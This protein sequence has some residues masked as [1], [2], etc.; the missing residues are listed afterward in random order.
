MRKMQVKQ[1]K[2]T[3]HNLLQFT[4][5]LITFSTF[6]AFE[7]LRK[8]RVWGSLLIRS[9]CNTD[10]KYG[11]LCRHLFQRWK[12]FL[13]WSEHQNVQPTY[14]QES[15]VTD[16]GFDLASFASESSCK[17]AEIFYLSLVV[18]DTPSPIPHSTIRQ[19]QRGFSWVNRMDYRGKRVD[20]F[21]CVN[22]KPVISPFIWNHYRMSV[23]VPSLRSAVHSCLISLTSAQP[24]V[25]LSVPEVPFHL[26]KPPTSSCFHCSST[27]LHFVTD[28]VLSVLQIFD[29]NCSKGKRKLAGKRQ[30]TGSIEKEHPTKIIVCKKEN[31]GG[32]EREKRRQHI[33]MLNCLL[34]DFSG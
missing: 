26:L 13:C 18:P 21:I 23:S 27:V 9:M 11:Y 5:A 33:L 16:K 15:L 29:G 30:Q 28:S 10:H 7:C 25:V 12:L 24:H 2:P 20:K 8:V 19:R 3:A 6:A 22:A 32:G 17:G 31:Y 14:Y 1:V 4:A 34:L